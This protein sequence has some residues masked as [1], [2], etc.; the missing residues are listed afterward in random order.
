MDLESGSGFSIV[1][2]LDGNLEHVA[3]AWRKIIGFDLYVEVTKCLQQIEIP[4][5]LHMCATC[6]D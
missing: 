4:N 6:S 3:H 2:L 1:S 5:I